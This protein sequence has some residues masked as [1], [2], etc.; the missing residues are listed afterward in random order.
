MAIFNINILIFI[1]KALLSR[2]WQFSS[3]QMP[4][5]ALSHFGA[6]C[7]LIYFIILPIR[8]LISSAKR[9]IFRCHTFP[10]RPSLSLSCGPGMAFTVPKLPRLREKIPLYITS[11]T[12]YLVSSGPLVLFSLG[13]DV[14]FWTDV[15][16][17]DACPS[18]IKHGLNFLQ[19]CT[20]G[21][22]VIYRL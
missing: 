22:Y 13:Q 6:S 4:V 15:P 3:V 11:P 9:G 19:I 12:P 10:R 5:F 21:K 8:D 1:G 18:W 2:V 16:P 20:M 17:G 7:P 14:Y